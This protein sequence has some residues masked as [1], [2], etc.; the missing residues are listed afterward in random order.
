MKT[1]LSS[2]DSKLKAT[3]QVCCLEVEENQSSD[4]AVCLIYDSTAQTVS[5]INIPLEH[6]LNALMLVDKNNGFLHISHLVSSDHAVTN[7][8]STLQCF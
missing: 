1:V 6:V 2:S 8:S 3:L 5:W 7:T 4:I